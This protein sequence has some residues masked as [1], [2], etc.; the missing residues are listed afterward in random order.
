MQHE[1]LVKH[2]QES[3]V[4]HALPKKLASKL[5]TYPTPNEWKSKKYLE[6]YSEKKEEEE[7]E[8]EDEEDC[9]TVCVVA[10]ERKASTTFYNFKPVIKPLPAPDKLSTLLELINTPKQQAKDTKVTEFFTHEKSLKSFKKTM[11]ERAEITNK[12]LLN[13]VRNKRYV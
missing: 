13:A 4:S 1:K 7:L 8:S 12:M 9:P 5:K 2:Q 11:N 6:L 10:R 3:V